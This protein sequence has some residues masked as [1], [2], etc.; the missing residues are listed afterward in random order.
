MQF[1]W[2]ILAEGA[3]ALSVTLSGGVLFASWKLLQFPSSLIVKVILAIFMGAL[4]Q[5]RGGGGVM[6]WGSSLNSNA[7]F[8][9][10][11]RLPVAYL[12][13]LLAMIKCSICSYQC[14][15]WYV[16][17]WRLA[18]HIYFCLGKC[19]LELARRPSHVVLAW[20][21]AGGS[22]PFGVPYISFS[23]SK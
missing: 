1:H 17:N 10:L 15:N 7:K 5:Q 22:I 2:S 14:D 4:A 16:S 12:L 13:G 8:V 23:N 6:H 18:C 9:K 19:S 21:F 3:I 11:P 20:H